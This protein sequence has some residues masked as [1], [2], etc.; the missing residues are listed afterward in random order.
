MRISGS[1]IIEAGFDTDGN[2]TLSDKEIEMVTKIDCDDKSITDLAG[3][4]HF[5][6]LKKLY[7]SSNHLTSLDV[8]KNMALKTLLCD[9]NQLK[10]LD[11]SGCTA[12]WWLNCASNQLTSLDVSGCSALAGLICD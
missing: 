6:A 8:S 4:E 11:V 2:G 7:C 9:Y 12:L 1:I 5:T 3:I 10:S